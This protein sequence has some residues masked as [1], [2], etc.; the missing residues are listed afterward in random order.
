ME[1]E[2]CKPTICGSD[3]VPPH[4]LMCT[5]EQLA[6]WLSR[7]VLEARCMDGKSYPPNTLYKLVCKIQRYVQEVKP[8]LDFHQ[9]PGFACLWKTLDVEMKH[10]RGESLGIKSKQAEAISK[11]QEQLW[12]S[13]CLGENSCSSA[14][15]HGLRVACISFLEAARTSSANFETNWTTWA[16]RLWAISVYYKCM[17][18]N[19][20]GGLQNRKVK[21]KQVIHHANTT[22][23]GRCFVRLLKVYCSHRFTNP[24]YLQTISN[25]QSSVMYARSPLGQYKLDTTVARLCARAE[26]GGYKT[27]HSW[28]NATCL[29]QKRSCWATDYGQNRT[30]KY[31]WDTSI[32][33]SV[34]R[35]AKNAVRYSE[36]QCRTSSCQENEVA[37]KQ[38]ERERWRPILQAAGGYPLCSRFCEVCTKMYWLVGSALILVCCPVA[39]VW[40]TQNAYAI[41]LRVDNSVAL[42]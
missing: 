30:Q 16:P 42:P 27:N 19:N 10:L 26:I 12:A 8:K 33:T 2:V 21:A 31:W 11:D 34:N 28:Q 13:G 41:I 14:W 4:L 9:D 5:V 7:F 22:Q 36:Q 37:G 25:T 3:E 15:Y 32:Q 23:S 1:G 29:F 40:C 38:L 24:F 39:W 18:K 6:H 20:A 35:V 17:S